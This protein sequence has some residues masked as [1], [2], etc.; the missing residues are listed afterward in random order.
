MTEQLDWTELNKSE[1]IPHCGF[2]LYF[3]GYV[4][5]LFLGLLALCLSSLEKCLLWSSA[6]FL[7][8]L[9]LLFMTSLYSPNINPI[10]NISFANILS[11]SLSC[12]FILLFPSLCKSFL[13]WYSSIVYFCF[14]LSLPEDRGSKNIALTCVKEHMACFYF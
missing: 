2:Y 13:I 6:R 9:F 12:F 5:H 1:M 3:P 8:W 11:Y 4:K 10:L 7:V 14:C